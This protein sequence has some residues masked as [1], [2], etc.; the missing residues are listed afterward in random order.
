MTNQTIFVLGTIESDAHSN[1]FG[2]YTKVIRSLNQQ[3]NY[4]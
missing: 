4:I 1:F 2:V 3:A